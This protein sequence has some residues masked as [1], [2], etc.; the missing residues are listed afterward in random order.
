MLFV[1]HRPG[2]VIADY[3]IRATSDNLDFFSAAHT[4]VSDSLQAQG[5]ISTKADFARSGKDGR[6][7]I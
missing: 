1:F 3:T 7:P 4:N 2:S 5:I 6:C